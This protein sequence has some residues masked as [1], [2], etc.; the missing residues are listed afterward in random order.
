MPWVKFFKGYF[1][2]YQRSQ[3]GKAYWE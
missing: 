1:K 3:E 2:G